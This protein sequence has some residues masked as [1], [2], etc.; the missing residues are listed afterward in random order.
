[1]AFPALEMSCPA[2]AVVLQPVNSGVT[3]SNATM[4]ATRSE[5]FP[6]FLLSLVVKLNLCTEHRE[7]IRIG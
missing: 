7:T 2:P 4:V 3:P 6:M 1:M 5:Y